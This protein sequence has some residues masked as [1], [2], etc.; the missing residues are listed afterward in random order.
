MSTDLAECGDAAAAAVGVVV[1]VVDDDGVAAT[2]AEGQ[3]DVD[4]TTI[5][6][7]PV[8]TGYHLAGVDVAAAEIEKS[9]ESAARMADCARM[10]WVAAN[11]VPSRMKLTAG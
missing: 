10:H 2:A 9:F 1:A 5:V 6:L 4:G 11:W 8:E 7:I 3:F